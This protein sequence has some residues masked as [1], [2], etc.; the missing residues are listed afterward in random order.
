MLFISSGYEKLWGETR[1]SLYA[2][3]RRWIEAICPED[4]ERVLRHALLKQT[5]GEYDEEY[6]IIRRDGTLRWIHD[7]AFPIRNADGTMDRIAGIAEDI[8]ERKQA[9]EALRLR[10]CQQ[11]ALAGLGQRAL[12]GGEFGQLLDNAAALVARILDI[13]FCSILELQ[14]GGEALLLRAGVGWRDGL[15]GR[16]IVPATGDSQAGFTV[17]SAAPAIVEDFRTETRFR[18]SALLF[19]HGVVG[20]MS[21]IIRARGRPYGVLGAHTAQRREFT[22]VDVHFLQS[23]ANILAA[24]IERRQLEQELLSTIE[25]EQQ[26]TGQDLHDGLCHQ[27][28]GIGF[29]TELIAHDLPDSLDGKSKLTQVVRHIRDAILEARTLARGLLPVRL[30]S[31][32]LMSALLDLASTTEQ[33]FKISCRFDCEQPVLIEDNGIA[34]HLYRIAQEAIHNAIKHGHA[35]HVTITLASSGGCATLTIADDGS[36]LPAYFSSSQG[37]GLRI[38]NYRAHMIGGHLSIGASHKGTKVACTWK[39]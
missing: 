7:R 13:Q 22:R 6:R 20:G 31:N 24:D 10:S 25:R 21:V 38:M 37:M 11:A 16:E 14:P 1:E 30:E 36:G 19:D 35:R 39:P 8:T 4:R 5:R 9:E 3:P 17:R 33:L 34:T 32:G 27:L 18:G 29:S 23:V 15:I 26:R 12:E 2:S 28:A